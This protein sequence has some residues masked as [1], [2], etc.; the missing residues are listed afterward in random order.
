M[1]PIKY[2]IWD[3]KIKQ[4]ATE[5]Y[6]FLISRSGDLWGAVGDWLGVHFSEDA[7]FQI[8]QCTGIDDADGGPIYE[9]DILQDV[10]DGYVVGTVEYNDG[11][12]ECAGYN[13]YDASD[14]KVNGNIHEDGDLIDH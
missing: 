1:R 2:R 13:M 12:F 14:Y 6:Q 8:E 10:T 5:D 3:S 4:Y 11:A 9:G 7:G